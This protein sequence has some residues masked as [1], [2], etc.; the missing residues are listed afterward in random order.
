MYTLYPAYKQIS[1]SK[2]MNWTENKNYTSKINQIAIRKLF[3]HHQNLKIGIE[4]GPEIGN[5]LESSIFVVPP[6]HS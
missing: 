3:S 4:S 6:P 2:T 5:S 1:R